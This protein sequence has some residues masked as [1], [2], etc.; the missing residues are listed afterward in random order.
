MHLLLSIA[1]LVAP[2]QAVQYGEIAQ[3][4]APMAFSSLH[5]YSPVEEVITNHQFAGRPVPDALAKKLGWWLP[6]PIYEADSTYFGVGRFPLSAG[7]EAFL[8]RGPGK[9][10]SSAISL[11]V[12]EKAKNS[13]RQPIELAEVW[14]DDLT[15]YEKDSWIVAKG[16]G[17]QYQVV[18]KELVHVSDQEDEN[19]SPTT[20]EISRKVT[21]CMLDGKSMTQMK[22]IVEGTKQLVLRYHQPLWDEKK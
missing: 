15:I 3:Y 13:F 16:K 4:F 6:E 12:Y 1:L 20:K 17:N 21:A 14:G 10:E 22:A 8:L 11:L 9:Y 2:P 19:T 7:Y 18:T 5:I